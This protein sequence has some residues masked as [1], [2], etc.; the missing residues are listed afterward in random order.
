MTNTLPSTITVT[1]TIINRRNLDLSSIRYA[2]ASPTTND[3][4]ALFK[5]KDRAEAYVKK[6]AYEFSI[7]DLKPHK[8]E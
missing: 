1:E 8:P 5:W 3:V 2:V 4:F 6:Y 7:I